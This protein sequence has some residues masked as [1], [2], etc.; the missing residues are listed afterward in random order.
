VK[1]KGYDEPATAYGAHTSAIP[2]VLAA[3]KQSQASHG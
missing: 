1:L 2:S 3:L